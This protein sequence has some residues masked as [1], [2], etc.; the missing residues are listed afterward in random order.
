[1]MRNAQPI[2]T[3][4]LTAIMAAVVSAGAQ[5]ASPGYVQAGGAADTHM[6][7][8]GSTNTHAQWKSGATLGAERAA[9]RADMNSDGLTTPSATPEPAAAAKAKAVVQAKRPAS[10]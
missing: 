6:N 4:L 2:R 3:S 8:Y 1:M 10:R 7:A 9:E 5:A